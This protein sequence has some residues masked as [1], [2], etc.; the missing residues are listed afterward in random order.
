MTCFYATVLHYSVAG[1]LETIISRDTPII[2]PKLKVRRLAKVS[3]FPVSCQL[4]HRMEDGV[5]SDPFFAGFLKTRD[6]LF[7]AYIN[8]LLPIMWEQHLRYN[9]DLFRTVQFQT[10]QPE[11]PKHQ[12]PGF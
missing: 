7:F 9:F 1:M 10:S 8:A 11:V 6:W 3:H 2:L 5:P 4:G 12:P